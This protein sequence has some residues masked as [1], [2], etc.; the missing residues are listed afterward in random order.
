[1]LILD[2]YA[3]VYVW[4]SHNSVVKSKQQALSIGL[5]LLEKDVLGECLSVD[6]PIYV[7]TEG[8]EPPFFTRFFGWDASKANM[9]GNSFE[10]KLA[11]LKGQT[12]KLEAP[13]R[14]SPSVT[15][16][17]MTRP[18]PTPNGLRRPCPIPNDL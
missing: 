5:A 4:V 1:M 13:S 2:C 18:S 6:T 3:E 11:M 15:P 8:H 9:L 16:N 10:R 17:G 12:H 14:N 7:V